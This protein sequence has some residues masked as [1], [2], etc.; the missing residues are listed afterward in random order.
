MIIITDVEYAEKGIHLFLDVSPEEIQKKVFQRFIELCN[1]FP[2]ET[3][4]PGI[5]HENPKIN[6]IIIP[7]IKSFWHILTMICVYIN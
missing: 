7:Y 3:D 2:S 1:E 4:K 6:E 5:V